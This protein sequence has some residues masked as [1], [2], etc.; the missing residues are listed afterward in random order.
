MSLFLGKGLAWLRPS[1]QGFGDRP[2]L[3]RSDSTTRES[4]EGIPQLHDFKG[5]M[6][7]YFIK[8]N[9]YCM[10]LLYIQIFLISLHHF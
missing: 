8:F 5:F 6:I 10:T 1:I 7:F 9:V 3:E 4:R 2:S